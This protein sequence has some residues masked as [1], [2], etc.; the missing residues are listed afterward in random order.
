V[1]IPKPGP[2]LDA[3]VAR[4]L[5]WKNVQWADFGAFGTPELYATVGLSPF[6]VGGYD[7]HGHGPVPQFSKEISHLIFD[8]LPPS[9]YA[10]KLVRTMGDV[11]H[12]YCHVS[13]LGKHIGGHGGDTAAEALCGAFL[14]ARE[15]CR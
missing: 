3:M 13:R 10:V 2:E 11:E 1:N 4:E 5:G 12:W 14:R 9:E 6:G 15:A 8:A 7:G